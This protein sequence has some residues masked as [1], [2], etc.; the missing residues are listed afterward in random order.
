MAL[1]ERDEG[2]E[3]PLRAALKTAPWMAVSAVVHGLAI[4]IL[5]QFDFSPSVEDSKPA[6]VATDP[7]EDVEVLAPPPLPPPPPIEP[8]KPREE[9]VAEPVV[10][11]EPEA[12]QRPDEREEPGLSPVDAPFLRRHED[13]LIGTGGGGGGPSGGDGRGPGPASTGNRAVQR[14]IDDAL[15]WLRRHQDLA[16]FWDCDGFSSRCE[17]NLCDGR[18]GALNDVGVTGLAALAFLG[19][20]QTTERGRHRGVVRAAL[21]WLES[22]QDPDD[23]CFGPKAG[24]HFMYGHALATLAMVEGYALSKP[25]HLARPAQRALDFIARARNPYAAWRY[26]F[27]PDGDNDVS[28]SGWMLFALFAGKDAGLAVD[29]AAISQGMAWVR[30]MTDPATGRT[31]Y[32]E[33][34]SLPAREPDA[35][36]RWPAEQSE[37]MTACAL[38]LD[39]FDGADPRDADVLRRAGLLLAKKPKWDE[40]A[41]TIDFY[42]W[43]YGTYAAWQL[44]ERAWPQWERALLDTVVAHQREGGD[45]AGSWDPQVDPWGREGGRVYSTALNAICLEVYFRQARLFGIR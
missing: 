37:S 45:E 4:L 44:E 27:P 12:K 36:D 11:S 5:C 26:A 20:G 7:D 29:D 8:V 41:G 16:G 13:G 35:T 33:R 30:S 6:I 2:F 23:G 21:R 43:Y 25:P 32:H 9:V 1:A 40:S 28:V 18:G 34:G 19:A 39:A 31:G 22:V 42:Y 3:E 38:L 15:R 24:Q 17:Q 10:S 14:P